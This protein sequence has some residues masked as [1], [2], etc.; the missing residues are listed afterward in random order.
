M[1]QFAQ[2]ERRVS[3]FPNRFS[4]V[5]LGNGNFTIT[6]NDGQ[7]TNPGTALNPENLNA[8]A[9]EVVYFLEDTS[10][11]GANFTAS[12]TNLTSYPDGLKVMFRPGR[13]SPANPTFNIEGVGSRPIRKIID[14]TGYED[15][16][17]NDM[18]EDKYELLIYDDTEQAFQ[19][20]NP[21]AD[22][23]SLTNLINQLS[24]RVTTLE[25][26][27]GQIGSTTPRYATTTGTATAYTVTISNI[28]SYT[29][30]LRVD[31]NMHL[32]NTGS[33]TLQV[34]SLGTRNI[35]F[36]GVPLTANMLVAGRT[37]GLIY[38]GASF[39]LQN[40]A[41][42]D[43]LIVK[44]NVANTFTALQTF[45][46]GL[47]VNGSNGVYFGIDDR[48]QFDDSNNRFNFLA[49]NGIPNSGLN[50]GFGIFNGLFVAR[51]GNSQLAISQDGVNYQA[52]ANTQVVNRF[53]AEQQIRFNTPRLSFLDSSQNPDK[54][55]QWVNFNGGMYLVENSPSLDQNPRGR[56][57]IQ[58]QDGIVIIDGISL[59][60]ENGRLQF[61]DGSEWRDFRMPSAPTQDQLDTGTAST[62]STTLQTVR[63]LTGLTQNAKLRQVNI[64]RA[65][66]TN[67][68][69]VIT[70]DSVELLN[71]T[72]G[73]DQPRFSMTEVLEEVR[74]TQ[75]ILIQHRNTASGSAV[76]TKWDIQTDGV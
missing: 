34:N 48:I 21:A 4:L 31:L 65:P 38:N 3:Q 45:N 27:V 66:N 72:L 37:Y 49:D 19:L 14:T 1:S 69:L 32:S 5:D 35:T 52:L 41:A 61:L 25:S 67:C 76:V 64:E 53:T 75:S 12:L 10:T 11:S 50:F 70:V 24:G 2:F 56:A 68:Q 60:G 29:A 58:V 13:N 63:E 59:R 16:I 74:A 42:N 44:N 9:D 62:T 17:V 23:T 30:G 8:M 15:L 36:Q 73:S 47:R 22:L 39:E 57:P 43:S 7:V 46:A 33:A 54:F 51:D 40:F 20:A 28:T 71:V 26:T 55:F 18:L 6:L